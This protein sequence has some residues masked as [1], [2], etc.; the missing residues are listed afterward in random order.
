MFI[1]YD[2]H[3]K[4]FR[5]YVI[6]PNEFV[7]IN[8][9]SES[10]DVI[11]DEIRFSPI[12]GPSQRSLTNGMDDDIGVQRSLM[13]SLKRLWFSNLSLEKAKGIELQSHLDVIFKFGKHLEEKHM[14][15][16]RFG[17]KLDKN[18]TL[19]FLERKDD[20]DD[21]N[22]AVKDEK[23]VEKESRVSKVIVEK[24]GPSDLGDVNKA[25]DLG[26]EIYETLIE[27]MLS[28][29]LTFDF[30]IEKGD[31]SNLKISCMIGHKFI[32]NAYIDLDLPMN[33]MSL[34]Y[35]NTIRNQGN[36]HR[37]LNFV[38]IGKDMHVFVGNMSHVTDF[39]IFENVEANID[40]SLSQV[41]FRRPFVETTKLILDRKKGLITFTDG[42]REVTF[43]TPYK[44]LEMD[45]LTSEGHDL[46]LSKVVLSDDDVR[47][48]CESMLDLEMG[49]YNEIHKLSLSYS[50]K[51]KRLDLEGPFEAEGS[52]TSEG[53]T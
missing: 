33:V 18:T 38:G 20:S 32:G 44:D 45:D 41:V 40:P 31:P 11:F 15:W 48:G 51:I 25:S 1:G 6:E 12:P 22:V 39:T 19:G 49:L 24:T 4:A 2:E 46:L 7:S 16:A 37:G 34:A 43:K 50:S 5:F 28:C 30:G 53:V 29:L 35:Y 10:R 52:R 47:R 13:R 9:I 17:K 8:S 42:V 26:N 21:H 14:T 27:K 3:S 36:E 23:M